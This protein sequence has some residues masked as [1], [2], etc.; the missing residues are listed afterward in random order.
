MVKFFLFVF[1]FVS[2]ASFAD[3]IPPEACRALAEYQPG[4][5]VHGKP[6]VPADLEEPAVSLPQKYSFDVTVD[7]AENLGLAIPAG[8]AGDLTVGTITVEKGKVFFNDKPLDTN[9]ETALRAEC[10]KPQEKDEKT[11]EKPETE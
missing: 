2:Y 8:T 7:V 10:E 4:V 3:D 5:D 1:L 6:V 9:A 11:E